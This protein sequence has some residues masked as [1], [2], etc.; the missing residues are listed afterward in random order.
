M[1][2]VVVST[3]GTTASTADGG[4]DATVSLSDGDLVSRVAIAL[5]CF[6]P[7]RIPPTTEAVGFLLA[8]K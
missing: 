5:G 7:C 2:I 8:S 1:S 3:S 4:G 6:E